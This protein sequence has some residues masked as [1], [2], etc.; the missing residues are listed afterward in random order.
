MNSKAELARF[1]SEHTRLYAS[2]DTGFDADVSGGDGRASVQPDVVAH[3]PSAGRYGGA[4]LFDAA[5]Y[6]WAEDEFTFPAAGNFPY[7]DESFS[8]SISMWLRSDPDEDLL[9]SVPVDPFHISRRAA[10]ASFYLDLTRPN[11]DRYGSPRKLRF[12]F[13]NDSPENDRFRGGQLIVV[14][15]LNWKRGDW[16]HVVATWRNA[17]SGESDGSA[18]VFIDGLRRGSMSGYEHKLT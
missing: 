4:L 9:P 8:G 17:N 5:Q 7:D 14:G 3:D 11:D 16:H 2:F 1:L 10:D 13:Y 6:G 18:E 12:G 15:D